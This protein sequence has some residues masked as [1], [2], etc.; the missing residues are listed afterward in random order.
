MD[1]E[2]EQ[3]FSFRVHSH[4]TLR[5]CFTALLADGFSPG[6]DV[7]RDVFL[8]VDMGS[9]ATDFASKESAAT[10]EKEKAKLGAIEGELNSL[11][12]ILKDVTASLN[13][14]DA[15]DEDMYAVNVNTHGRVASF[16]GLSI[17]VLIGVGAWQLW[18]LHSFFKA[19]VSYLKLLYFTKKTPLKLTLYYSLTI[20]THLNASMMKQSCYFQLEL[21]IQKQQLKLI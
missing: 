13:Y 19:K 8:K 14:I 20:E 9:E 12:G 18:Y 3:K 5:F 11:D 16:S 7:K 17:I 6:P 21:I 1:V 15:L 4:V 2:G 10:E